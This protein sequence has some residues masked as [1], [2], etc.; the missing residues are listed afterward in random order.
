MRNAMVIVRTLLGLLFI[1]ASVVVLFDLVEKPELSGVAKTFNDGIFAVGYFIPM[2][3]IVELTC[4]IL[5]VIGRF[6]PLATVLIAPVIVNIFMFHA[7]IDNSGLPVAIFLVIAN[8][9]V[10]C[11]YRDAHRGLLAAR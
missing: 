6:V 2:L 11:S 3:K 4:G 9:F 7:F 10:A 5:F 1:F 8:I